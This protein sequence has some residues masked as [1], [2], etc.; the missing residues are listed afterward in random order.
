MNAAA[1]AARAEASR[2][3]TEAQTL[4]RVVRANVACS[5][6]RMGEAHV[7]FDRAE[8]VGPVPSPWSEL[9]WI[10]TYA[11]LDHTLVPVD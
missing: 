1:Q 4:K 3:R 8:L 11:T 2:L 5:R 7:E 6:E 10:E 9:R